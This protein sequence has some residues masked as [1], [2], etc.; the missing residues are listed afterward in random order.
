MTKNLKFDVEKLD[1]GYIVNVNYQPEKY[2]DMVD[3]RYFFDTVEQIH[4]LYLEYL[5]K[6]A[7]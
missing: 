1:N 7:Q 6:L 3:K 4:A 2:T 5:Q